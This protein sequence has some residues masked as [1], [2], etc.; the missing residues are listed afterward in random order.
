MEMTNIPT[1]IH[2]NISK[3]TGLLV[4]I[5]RQFIISLMSIAFIFTSVH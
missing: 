1:R 3:Q 4:L 5:M 2:E